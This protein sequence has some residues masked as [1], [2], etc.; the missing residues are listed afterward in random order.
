MP[1]NVMAMIA[2]VR[3]MANRRWL[4]DDWADG[5]LHVCTRPHL[6]LALQTRVGHGADGNVSV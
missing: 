4:M 5:R 6:L 3:G 2:S 1:P